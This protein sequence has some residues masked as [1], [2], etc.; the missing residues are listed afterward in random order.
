M[1]LQLHGTLQKVQRLP[2][3]LVR[4]QLQHGLHTG[5][6]VGVLLQAGTLHRALH[7]QR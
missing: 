6:L 1:Q 4:V 3:L 2:G 7:V 5:I